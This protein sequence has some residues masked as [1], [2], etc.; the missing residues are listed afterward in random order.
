MYRKVK[1]G[2]YCFRILVVEMPRRDVSTNLFRLFSFTEVFL[3]S[4]STAA[5]D[6]LLEN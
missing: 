3:I 5:T 4:I 2:E 1:S 6:Y